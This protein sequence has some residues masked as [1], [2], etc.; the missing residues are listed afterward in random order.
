MKL[1][2]KMK[3]NRKNPNSK[4][5]IRTIALV[6][7]GCLIG[8]IYLYKWQP[9]KEPVLPQQLKTFTL[10]ELARFNGSDPALPIYLGLNGFVYDVTSGKKYYEQGGTYNW[11]AGKDSSK[12]L[13]LIGGD[14]IMRKYPVIGILTAE[15]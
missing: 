11:L 14:I 5:S 2:L 15:Q 10:T 12:D 13:N 1:N 7:L 4:V 3:T 6:L 8:V 9:Q